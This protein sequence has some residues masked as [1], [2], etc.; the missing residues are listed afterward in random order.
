MTAFGTHAKTSHELCYEAVQEA[1]KDGNV[2]A[3]SIDAIVVGRN[4]FMDDGE[5]QRLFAGIVAN[6]FQRPIPI[7]QISAACAS[8]S[9]ALYN[10]AKLDAKNVLVLGVEKLTPQTSAQAT[11][12]ILTAA[13]SVYEQAEGVIFPA[14]YALVAQH[15]MKKYDV[16][17]DDLGLV[18]IKNHQNACLNEKA[19]FFNKIIT[20]ELVRKSPIVCSPFRLLD[21]SISVDGA[22]AIIIS[23][24]KTDIEI[25]GAA[26]AT[27][28]LGIFESQDM[29][30]F[31]AT[32]TAAAQA[33][34]KAQIS[35][36]DIQCA[37]VH[38]AFT[39]AELMA[40]EDLGFAKP[41]EAKDL[42][43]KGVT[44]LAGTLPINTS[45]GLKARGHPVSATGL[46]QIYELVKQMRGKAGKRQVHA[47]KHALAHNM[48]GCGTTAVVHILRNA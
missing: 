45:G 1:L 19:K 46:A 42:I 32:K 35:A 25:A 39:S 47:I 30:S 10:A 44:K 23:S 7:F 18:A 48:A 36:A 16:S 28:R 6:L 15:Y 12:E 40:Y 22:A 3:S 31:E 24:E 29:A 4:D 13:E 43:R 38:D 2:D 37:E 26:M 9:V 27:S 33:F 21:C 5:H 41:G 34:A 11:S 8:G 14:Q 20:M 17:M